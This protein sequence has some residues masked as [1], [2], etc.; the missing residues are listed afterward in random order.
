MSEVHRDTS[1]E[2]EEAFMGGIRKDDKHKDSPWSVVLSLNGTPT[3]FEINTGAEVTAIS[4]KGSQRD[5]KSSTHS[6]RENFV[7]PK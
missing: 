5:R 3:K 6:A 2:E 7:G 4:T 1:P